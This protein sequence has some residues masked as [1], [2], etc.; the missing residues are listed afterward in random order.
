MIVPVNVLP[1][2]WVLL[3]WLPCLGQAVPAEWLWG[4]DGLT[5]LQHIPVTYFAVGSSSTFSSS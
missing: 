1:F 5:R 3:A 2:G 4:W